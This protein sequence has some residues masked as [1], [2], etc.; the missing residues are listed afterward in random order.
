MITYIIENHKDEYGFKYQIY[1][2]NSPNE[3]PYIYKWYKGSHTVNILDGVKKEIDCFT[4]DFHKNNTTL[5]RVK[6]LI[7]SHER[8]LKESNGI[9]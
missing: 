2:F 5:N 3:L 1:Y 7:F 9:Y 4:F 8:E 6:S